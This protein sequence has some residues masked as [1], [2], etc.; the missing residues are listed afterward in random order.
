MNRADGK[1][2]MDMLDWAAESYSRPDPTTNDGP[3]SSPN[4]PTSRPRLNPA[5]VCWLMGLPPAWTNIE[6]TSFGAAEMAS[7]LSRLQRRLFALCADSD[8]RS[9]AA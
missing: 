7:Y 1:S 9:K 8:S 6:H 2:R 4:V 3:Q 5:F